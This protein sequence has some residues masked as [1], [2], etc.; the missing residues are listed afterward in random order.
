[1]ENSAKNITSS[2]AAYR[3]ERRLKL[4]STTPDFKEVVDFLIDTTN[5]LSVEQSRRM[6]RLLNTYSG[7]DIYDSDELNTW[8]EEKKGKDGK[9]IKTSDKTKF[10]NG[11]EWK[12]LSDE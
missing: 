4:Y 8:W 12:I 7:L 11:Y 9:L 5:N 6:F 10:F 1:L 2:V 3:L